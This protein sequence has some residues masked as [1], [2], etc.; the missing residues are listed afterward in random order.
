MFLNER[1]IWSGIDRQTL[2][3]YVWGIYLSLF[4]HIY[5]N[6]RKKSI[7][8]IIGPL[9]YALGHLNVFTVYSY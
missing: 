6:L 5:S 9:S 1:Q 7:L 3:P 4:I 8:K 2:W